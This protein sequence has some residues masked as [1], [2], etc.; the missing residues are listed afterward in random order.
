L[1]EVAPERKLNISSNSKVGFIK[2]EKISEIVSH[3]LEFAVKARASD[4]HIEPQEMTTRVRYRID[5]I[6]QEKLTIPRE[7]HDSL[8]SRIKILAGMKIDEK[9]YARW[10]VNFKAGGEDTRVSPLPTS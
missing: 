8:I 7:L 5:G 10:T 9:E 3:V 1:K 4:I 6:L 2:E